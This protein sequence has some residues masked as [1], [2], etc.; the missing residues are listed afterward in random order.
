MTRMQRISKS[1]RKAHEVIFDDSSKIVIMNDIHRGNGSEADDFAKNQN[2]YYA[3]LELY[4]QNKYTYIELGDGDE[5]WENDFAEVAETHSRIYQLMSQ[6]YEEGR[7]YVV[8]G[9][10]DIIKRNNPRLLEGYFDP[11]L[12]KNIPLF[13]GIT[14]HE[15]IILKYAPTGYQLVLMHG[16]QAD[17]FNDTYW[18]VARFLVRYLWQP[19]QLIGVKDPTRAAKNNFLRKMIDK[20]LIQW[21]DQE[22]KLL[23]AGH[24]HRTVFPG[25]GDPLYFNSGCCVLPRHITAL[26][27]T[28]GAISLVQWSH[29]TRPDGTVYIGKDVLAGPVGIHN[30]FTRFYP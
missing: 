10:H 12:K 27:I 17:V 20:I 21:T 26:E 25:Q 4:N 3:A 15:S 2:K 19:L 16:H 18:R 24:T 13:P 8:Y 28:G 29:K 5:L 22:K 9:N 30:Y 14:I 11:V 23:I 1:Y 7:L 6:F